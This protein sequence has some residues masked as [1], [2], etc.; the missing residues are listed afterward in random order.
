MSLVCKCKVLPV[1]MRKWNNY[2]VFSVRTFIWQN[3]CQTVDLQRSAMLYQTSSSKL[4]GSNC[5]GG[6]NLSA[7]EFKLEPSAIEIVHVSTQW[8]ANTVPFA[9]HPAPSAIHV[10]SGFLS[11]FLFAIIGSSLLAVYTFFSGCLTVAWDQPLRKWNSF[12]IQMCYFWALPLYFRR[13]NTLTAIFNT[14]PFRTD[15]HFGLSI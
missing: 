11:L 14:G 13:R 1:R 12:P 7:S 6:N 9:I 10:L 5:S 4:H 8:Q 2:G 15:G 3:C